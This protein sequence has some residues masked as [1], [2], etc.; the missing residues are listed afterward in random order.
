MRHD[1]IR[2]LEASLLKYV[3]KDVKIEP[4][5]LP[6]GN[7]TFDHATASTADKARLDV[8]A[9]GVHSP[10]GKNFLDVR[11]THLN[12]ECYREKTFAQVY[13]QQE[14]EKKRKYGQR[15]VQVEKATFT[16]L[17]FS[18]SGGMAPECTTYH[19]RVAT[20]I[21]NKTKEDYSKVMNHI[22]TRVRFSILKSTLV[23]IRGERGKK[24]KHNNNITELSFNT[25]PEMP[26]Y[27]P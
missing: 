15:I 12:S 7:I 2:D 5:L 8:S 18:T 4:E 10:Y 24:T 17:V 26:S 11:V 22:R 14:N 23:A 16:P 27:E 6:V 25:M 9:V 20:L 21:S 13:K 1:R 19:K 3:C